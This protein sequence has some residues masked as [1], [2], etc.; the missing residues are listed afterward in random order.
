MCVNVDVL[1]WKLCIG[2]AV[3]WLAGWLAGR[4]GGSWENT[5][6]Y[7][8]TGS[9]AAGG[10]EEVRA[11]AARPRGE[12]VR[13]AV[14]AGMLQL[15]LTYPT[16]LTDNFLTLCNRRRK[17][18]SALLMIHSVGEKGVFNSL[19]Y[20]VLSGKQVQEKKMFCLPDF[21]SSLHPLYWS[22]KH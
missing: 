6:H 16:P 4:L 7:K 18:L 3:R 17:C 9:G 2:A 19:W 11:V 14:L 5:L 21:C 1:L 8:N 12:L 10:G 15:P 13:L 20:V 22:T